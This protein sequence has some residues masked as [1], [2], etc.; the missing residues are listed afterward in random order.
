MTTFRTIKLLALSALALLAISAVATSAQAGT[1]TA[2]TYPANVYG[3]NMVPHKLKTNLGT[4]ECAPFLEGQ[5]AAASETLTMTPAYAT[6]CS[7]GE[8]EVHV[9]VNGCDFLLHAG[10]ETGEHSVAGSMDILCPVGRAIDFE[11]T[12]EPICHLTLPAQ[13]GLNSLSFTDR[14]APKDVDLHFGLES[15]VYRLDE[16]CP[17]AGNYNNG[18]YGS[19]TTTMVAAKQGGMVIPFMVD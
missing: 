11:I 15:L 6:Q 16:G 18:S 8:T 4:M 9:K 7:L 14:T 2:S 17:G 13:T 19:G 1:F 5:L 10:E 12:S 3:T